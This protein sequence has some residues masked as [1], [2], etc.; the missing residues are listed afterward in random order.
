[1]LRNVATFYRILKRR[2]ER[3]TTKKIL[4]TLK[5]KVKGIKISLAEALA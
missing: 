4:K 2:R 1:M 3:R 5:V